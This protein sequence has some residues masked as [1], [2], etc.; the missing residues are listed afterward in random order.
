MQVRVTQPFKMSAI[1]DTFV[2]RGLAVQLKAAGAY[3]Y[4]WSGPAGSLRNET[5][6]IATVSPVRNTKYRVIGTD[7]ARCFN[8]TAYAQVRIEEPPAVYAGPDKVVL[9]GSDVTLAAR[10]SPDVV[11]YEWLP[12]EAVQCSSCAQTTTAPRTAQAY[13]LT[14]ANTFGC[15]AKDTINITL[16]CT[17]SR[18][19]IPNAFT[20][21]RNGLNET[22]SV[23]GRGATI[24]SFRI[25]DRGGAMMFQA[26]NVQLNDA[27]GAWDGSYNGNIAASGTYAYVVE[28]MCDTG[29]PFVKKGTVTLIK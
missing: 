8:D 21:D 27:K 5:S 22:F 20:P 19:H 28:L 1:P 6:A 4:L 11:S 18:V 24:K 3:T 26:T 25:F 15:I 10:T 14:V 16:Q 13:S 2:C 17:E 7:S 12:K 29:E 9:T 23:R